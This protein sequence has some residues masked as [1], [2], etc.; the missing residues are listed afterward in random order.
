[1][2]IKVGNAYKVR[3]TKR[4]F[5][6]ESEGSLVIGED[7][8]GDNPS[9]SLYL[10]KGSEGEVFVDDGEEIIFSNDQHE[11]TLQREWFEAVEDL[12]GLEEYL[13]KLLEQSS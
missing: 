6:D 5:Y 9:C 1:M 13:D 2:D 4:I 8:W 7:D 3:I 12:G 11:T 10:E